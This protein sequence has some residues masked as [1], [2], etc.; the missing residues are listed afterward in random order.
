MTGL[1][2]IEGSLRLIGVLAEGESLSANGANDAL[3]SFNAMLDSWSNESLIVF[4]DLREVFALSS[5]GLSQTYTWGTGGTLNSSRPMRVKKA[6]IQLSSAT[7]PTEI[8]VELLTMEEYASVILKTLQSNFPLYA[9]IDD[10]Y[11]T[12]N[13]N[14][15]PV[16][17]DSTNSLVFYSTK[18]LTQASLNV[19]LSLPPG[20]LRALRYNLAIELAP[21]YGKVIPDPVTA[22]AIESKAAVKRNNTK[23]RYLVVDS[24]LRSGGS[25]YNWRTDGYER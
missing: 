12:R 20:Y 13:V 1:Q 4:P 23:P 16:P 25:V 22:I 11:P 3:D 14:V 6:L 7:T 18:P 19:A 5:V 17:T 2:L 21:E 24:A 9:Y 15:W 8:P 10:A